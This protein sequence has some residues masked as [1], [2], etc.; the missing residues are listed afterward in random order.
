L[1]QDNLISDWFNFGSNTIMNIYS[2]IFLHIEY[3]NAFT[4]LKKND[5]Q[6]NTVES[7]D[8]AG[9]FYEYR[10]MDLMYLV[11]LMEHNEL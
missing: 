11:V 4:F 8:E 6:E 7:S 3:L 10:I 9:G 5:R 1:Q 2:S